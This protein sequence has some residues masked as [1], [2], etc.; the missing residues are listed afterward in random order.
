MISKSGFDLQGLTNFINAIYKFHQESILPVP[1]ALV[2]GINDLTEWAIDDL[3]NIID[4][5]MKNEK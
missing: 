3:Q 4:S 5:K 2:A 1:P